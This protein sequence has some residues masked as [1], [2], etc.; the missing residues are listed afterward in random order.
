MAVPGQESPF[1]NK[2]RAHIRS[3]YEPWN[4][5]LLKNDPDCADEFSAALK[6][7]RD[8]TSN[9]IMRSDLFKDL[10][11]KIMTRMQWERV[12]TYTI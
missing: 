4:K 8:E 12:S 3:Y 9:E 6:K 2:Q 10:N 7:W 11:T 5:H 1:T